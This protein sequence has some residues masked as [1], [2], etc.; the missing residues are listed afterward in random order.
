MCHTT[1]AQ[2]ILRQI[3]LVEVWAEIFGYQNMALFIQSLFAMELEE[4]EVL[5]QAEALL[6]QTTRTLEL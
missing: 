1:L 2:Q 5:D 3:A 6:L 4:T